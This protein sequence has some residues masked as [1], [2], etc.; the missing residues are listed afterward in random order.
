MA[1]IRVPLPLT[2]A[3]VSGGRRRADALRLRVGCW[4]DAALMAAARSGSEAL[5]RL[6]LERGAD[7]VRRDEQGRTAADWAAQQ[8]RAQVAALLTPGPPATP[9]PSG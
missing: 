9:P 2:V 7:R 5:V 4:S 3:R 8:G 6:L 1:R